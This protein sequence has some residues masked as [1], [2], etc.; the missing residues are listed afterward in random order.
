[1]KIYLNNC[2]LTSSSGL[3]YGANSTVYFTISVTNYKYVQLTN[4]N[5]AINFT[6]AYDGNNLTT[7]T[8]LALSNRIPVQIQGLSLT[9]STGNLTQQVNST[10]SF[11]LGTDFSL[12]IPFKV[13]M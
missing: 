2:S 1:M 7:V 5:P 13:S 11:T 8:S 9:R 3:C 12:N 4:S 6:L 10:V